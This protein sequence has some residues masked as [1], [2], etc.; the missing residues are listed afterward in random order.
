MTI[1]RVKG[2]KIFRDWHGKMRCY[3]RLTGLKIDLERSH[4]VLLTSWL[5]A[6][7]YQRRLM[8]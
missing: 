8:L 1:V 4:L 5:N 3:H 2:F 7:K 6:Q